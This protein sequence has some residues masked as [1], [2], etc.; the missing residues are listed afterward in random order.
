MTLTKSQ[1]YCSVSSKLS[2]S[3]VE[4]VTG[5]RF[6]ITV[7]SKQEGSMGM[8]TPVVATICNTESKQAKKSDFSY[9][10]CAESEKF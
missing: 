1:F 2:A 4:E 8:A 7:G 9:W 5:Q 10:S 6:W 3:L